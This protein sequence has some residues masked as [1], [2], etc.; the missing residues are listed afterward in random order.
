MIFLTLK[1]FSSALL[2]T[3]LPYGTQSSISVCLSC[4]QPAQEIC[5]VIKV[6]VFCK[7]IKGSLLVIW[8]FKLNV[9]VAVVVHLVK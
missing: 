1:G 5:M 6:T 3:M 7:N 8:K 9:I 2:V 4:L